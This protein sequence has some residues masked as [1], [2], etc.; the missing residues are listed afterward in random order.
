MVV[1]MNSWVVMVYPSVPWLRISH[2]IVYRLS[3]ISYFISNSVG[4]SRK[5]KDDYPADCS[6]ICSILFDPYKFCYFVF[7]YFRVCFLCV[8]L[9]W[10][11]SLWIVQ[12]QWHHKKDGHFTQNILRFPKL[13]YD[14]YW[15]KLYI[16]IH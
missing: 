14:W 5:A 2:V 15:G 12:Y 13:P 6:C 7:F 3:Q 10:I 4:V 8:I 9:I 16:S 1:N 11:E